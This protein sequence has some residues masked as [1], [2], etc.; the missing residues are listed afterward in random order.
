M[1][2]STPEFAQMARGYAEMRHLPV[3]HRNAHAAFAAL[4]NAISHGRYYD[5]KPVADPVEDVVSQIERLRDMLLA[6]PLALSVLRPSSV[7]AGSPEQPIS[8]VLEQVRRF[9]YS[10]FPVYDGGR[11]VGILTTN[12]IA[13][14][15]AEQLGP[16]V[17]LAEDQPVRDVLAYSEPHERAILVPRTTTAAEAIHLIS[18]G[19]E[20]GRPPTALLI[21]ENGKCSEAALTIVV[22]DDMPVLSASLDIG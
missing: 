19:G 4:R 12:T 13:R 20:A 10:Q 11:Y 6:P 3:R 22:A 17:G 21:T 15:L 2:I 7:C 18:A 16:R 9:D 8:V 14:W 1:P 5:G